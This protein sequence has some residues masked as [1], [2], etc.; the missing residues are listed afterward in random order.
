MHFLLIFIKFLTRKEFQYI[1][2]F[3]VQERST[4]RRPSNIFDVLLLLLSKDSFF[5]FKGTLQNK[6]MSSLKY[7]FFYAD[8]WQ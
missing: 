3:S 8:T 1:I 5:Y 6:T 7:L 4:R 2:C